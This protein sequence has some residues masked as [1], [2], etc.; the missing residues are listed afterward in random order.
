MLNAQTSPRQSVPLRLPCDAATGLRIIG[1]A[2]ATGDAGEE[3]QLVPQQDPARRGLPLDRQLELR[4]RA[5][6][7][8]RA[9]ELQLRQGQRR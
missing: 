4:Q 1:S 2:Q 3:R 8:V 9:V 6:Q 7:Q 5:L